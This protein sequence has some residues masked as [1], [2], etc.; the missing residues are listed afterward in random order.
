MPSNW[1]DE[2]I[3]AAFS[4]GFRAIGEVVYFFQQLEDELGRIVAFLINPDF[5]SVGEVIVCEL[6][7]KQ[8]ATLAYTI[9]AKYIESE[10][11]ENLNE[12]TAILSKAHAAEQKRNTLL[13]STFGVSM[14]DEPVLQRS[15]RTA[16]FK[17]GL[18]ESVEALDPETMEAYRTSMSGVTMDLCMFMARVFPGWNDRSWS[19]EPLLD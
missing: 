14:L 7:F 13:H 19:R 18:K 12:W 16:K 1:S 11:G 3:D 17:K 9:F 4:E 8:L 6:S 5:D 15:K 10:Q 2:H